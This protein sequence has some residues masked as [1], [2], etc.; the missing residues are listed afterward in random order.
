M[1]VLKILFFSIV[2]FYPNIK[3]L[4]I[5]FA[6]VRVTP[7]TSEISFDPLK[8]IKTYIRLTVREKRLDELAL[9]GIHPEI[10]VKIVEVVVVC[11]NKRSKRIQLLFNFNYTLF[12][13]RFLSNIINKMLCF[14]QTRA[15][16][17]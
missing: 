5:L 9:F 11:A 7:R 16:H 1:S 17:L 10:V 4:S 13:K 3:R 2:D 15:F 14:Q 8:R 6:T 12:K